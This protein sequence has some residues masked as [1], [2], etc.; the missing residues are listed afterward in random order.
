MLE[1]ISEA[2]PASPLSGLSGLEGVLRDLELVPE[3]FGQ[4]L[5]EKA[6]EVF[7]SVREEL[8]NLRKEK[9]DLLKENADLLKENAELF[10]GKKNSE[11]RN[12]ELVEE[13]QKVQ[14]ALSS[15]KNWFP[16]ND[17]QPRF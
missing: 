16:T 9:A 14:E 4:E 8:K 17:S 1:S 6:E 11:I 3:G 13:F 7:Q 15:S 5:K 2:P 12:Q 10:Q